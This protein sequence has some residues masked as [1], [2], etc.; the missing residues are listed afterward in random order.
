M[1]NRE[2]SQEAKR[3]S[4][5][6]TDSANH[7]LLTQLAER[8]RALRSARGMSRKALAEQS[9]VSERHLANLEAGAGNVS[10][11]VLGQIAGALSRSAAELLEPQDQGGERALIWA[12]LDQ[13]NDGELK[14]AR[15]LLAREFESNAMPLNRPKSIALIGLRGAGKSSLGARVSKLLNLEFSELNSRIESLAGCSLSEVHNLLGQTAYRRYERR[16]VEELAVTP[17]AAIVA[18]PGGIVSDP[19]TFNFVLSRF[20]TVWLKATPEEH[21]QRVLAQGDM[22][23][24]TGNPEA[25]DDLKRILA[26]RAALY[27]KAD[28]QFETSGK[29]IEAAAQELAQ[30]LKPEL[31]LDR[32][33]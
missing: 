31:S 9:G 23:P 5:G 12:L 27:N 20:T 26:S 14:R 24:M 13:R 17:E 30:L 4:A 33:K 19:S 15:Q 29:S 22:R 25:M 10:V 11:V 16:A 21:M 7:P 3:Q 2:D 1:S 32:A 6:G 28:F 18:T 8:V